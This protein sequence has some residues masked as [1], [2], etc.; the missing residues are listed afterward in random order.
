LDSSRLIFGGVLPY[1]DY[2]ARY[3]SADL[4]LD[5]LPFNAGTTASD[6]LWAGLPV[7][8]CLGDSFAGRMGGSLLNSV[9]LPDLI[10]SSAG[11]YQALAISLGQ[12]PEKI[13]ALKQKLQINRQ[14]SPLFDTRLYTKNLEIAFKE[15]VKRVDASLPPDDVFV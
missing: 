12:M 2:L 3:R 13:R 7:L 6:A 15:M 11:E 10:T 5:T 1:S 14:T 8:T 9:G 4:F